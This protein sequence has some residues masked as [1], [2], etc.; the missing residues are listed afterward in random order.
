MTLFTSVTVIQLFF[1]LLARFTCLTTGAYLEDKVLQLEKNYIKIKEDLEA[2][3]VNLETKVARLEAQVNHQE[4]IFTALIK[5]ERDKKFASQKGISRNVETNEHYKRNAAPRT[6]GEVFATNPLLDSGMY[7]IDPDGQG[8][9]DNAIN[10]YCN[11]TTGSTS[12]LHDSELKID[13]GK[14]S[15]PGCYSRKIN[16]YATE[17]QIAALVGLSNNCSQTIIYDCSNAPLINKDVSYSWWNDKNGNKKTFSS[18]GMANCDGSLRIQA[19]GVIESKQDLPMT[20]LNFGG[21]SQ[22]SGQHT[23]GRLECTGKVKVEGM[24]TS[25]DDLWR[26]GNTMNGIYSIVANKKVQ[27]VFCDFN[28]RLGSEKGFQTWIGFS[29]VKSAQVH[30]YAKM[31]AAFT[32]EKTPLPFKEARINVGKGM[33][34]STG[35]FTAPRTGF[36]FFSFTGL[37]EFPLASTSKTL[38]VRLLL[39][40]TSVGNAWV[41]EQHTFKDQSSPLTLQSILYLK[42]GQKV[43]LEIDTISTGVKLFDRF[44]THFTGFLLEEEDMSL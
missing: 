14:C 18:T 40:G 35:K 24:P 37:A 15:D 2:K 16:Y 9:G 8:V 1:L 4:S 26:I 33:D 34:L 10:V 21:T 3:V 31:S 41:S 39:D 19:I 17:K 7:W 29:N 28:K 44:Y 5:S 12:V 13:V 23:L 43:W 36:Y 22:G 38:G 25:C 20:R 11:M 30:F 32:K 27:T 42:S 6:C